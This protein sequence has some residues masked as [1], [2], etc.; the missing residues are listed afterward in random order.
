M[1]IHDK[2]IK[3]LREELNTL[4][5]NVL[6]DGMYVGFVEHTCISPD[7][8]GEILSLPCTLKLKSKKTVKTTPESLRNIIFAFTMSVF[9]TK[10]KILST[11]KLKHQLGKPLK[12]SYV[13]YPHNYEGMFLVH[14]LPEYD[15]LVIWEVVL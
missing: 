8:C 4:Y 10:F 6:G 14:S 12:E 2:R 11:P 3:F 7:I 1:N 15:F 5:N 9:S 13:F